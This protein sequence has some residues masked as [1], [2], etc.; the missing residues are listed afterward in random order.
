MRDSIV[1]LAWLDVLCLFSQYFKYVFPDGVDTVVVKVNSE[2]NFPCSVMSIQDI[3][4]RFVPAHPGQAEA[5]SD[6]PL[7]QEGTA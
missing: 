4:V 1:S 6:T 3:Q 5:C 7:T 2:M